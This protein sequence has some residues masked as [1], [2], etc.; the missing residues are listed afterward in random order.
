MI[1]KVCN[2]VC[3]PF[4]SIWNKTRRRVR[5]LEIMGSSPGML[6]R[7]VTLHPH[8]Y[9]FMLLMISYT[10]LI[11]VFH[12]FDIRLIIQ[13]MP[14]ILQFDD[15]VNFYLLFIITFNYY[16]FQFINYRQTLHQPVWKSWPLS[17]VHQWQ[18]L[19]RLWKTHYQRLW[20]ENHLYDRLLSC[21]R[22][23]FCDIFKPE[24]Q[25]YQMMAC[26]VVVVVSGTIC[27]QPFWAEAA[28]T[29]YLGQ[30]SIDLQWQE[31]LIFSRQSQ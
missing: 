19:Q 5:P 12:M 28:S 31:G 1:G 2:F 17:S 13:T 25:R 29:Q 15:Y 18:L 9:L 27:C 22:L 21:C 14:S 20:L 23:L 11:T 30:C 6:N 24:I 7:I 26:F 3:K 10:I 4:S 8:F 16:L